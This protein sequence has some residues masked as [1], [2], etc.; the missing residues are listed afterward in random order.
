[1]RE[2][3]VSVVI[4]VYCAEKTLIQC[5]NSIC[6]QT[7]KDFEIICVDDGSTDNSLDILN[8]YASK[9]RR[10]H[11]LHQENQGAGVA[12]NLGLSYATGK[13]V[14]FLDA[15]DYFMPRLLELAYKKAEAT[16]SDIVL[17]AAKQ[18]NQEKNVSFLA[19]WILKTK[20]LPWKKCFSADE[21]ADVLFQ[22][23]T[24][25]PWSKMFRLDFIRRENLHFQA[26]K[27]ANDVFF[28][29]IALALA[30][31]ISYIKQ[32]L[33]FYRVNQ[34]SSLQ[35][36][37]A[38][39]PTNFVDAFLAL[40]EELSLCNIFEKFQ[41]SFLKAVQAN[42]CYHFRTISINAL[43]LTQ[44]KEILKQLGIP[45]KYVNI[46]P[47]ISDKNS[48]QHKIKSFFRCFREHGMRYAL[49]L[50]IISVKTKTKG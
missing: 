21:V 24:P 47:D 29:Y 22:I 7:L 8:T 19:P 45:L 17:Y 28:V 35:S 31:R 4:P 44:R 3:K 43:D 42:C 39:A 30:R 27:N 18:Y 15:D 1:M 26:L 11:I 2:T 34:K 33:L 5:L 41:A 40:R 46:K 14:V 12:R 36:N 16:C 10:F 32:P 20:C 38:S 23:T 50:A 13:Y 37:K 49:T 9:D 6:A 48:I 25:E